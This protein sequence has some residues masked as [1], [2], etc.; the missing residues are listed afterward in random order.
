VYSSYRR[1][2]ELTKS[3]LSACLPFS[4]G[5]LLAGAGEGAGEDP[6]EKQRAHA[7]AHQIYSLKNWFQT[8]L[9]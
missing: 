1:N 6:Q 4:T 5:V 7:Q 3:S 8:G 9:G 2:V